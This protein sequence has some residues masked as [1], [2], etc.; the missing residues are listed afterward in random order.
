MEEQCGVV[1]QITC[2]NCPAAY[3]GETDR[4]LAKR[5]KEHQR[6]G[7]PVSDHLVEHNHSFTKEDVNTERRIGSV[8]VWLIP[9]TLPKTARH[10]TVIEVVTPS[11][12]STDSCCHHVTLVT[13]MITGSHVP[14]TQKPQFSEK[15]PWSQVESLISPDVHCKYCVNIVIF[16]C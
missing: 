16:H 8:E 6:P 1:Y 2:A 5:L 13:C 12:Q 9:F 10:S 3:V 11:P 14:T 7:S 15:D 4:P